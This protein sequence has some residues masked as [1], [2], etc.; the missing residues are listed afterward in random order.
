MNIDASPAH[1]VAAA[2]HANPYP[3]Y[4]TL[5]D[6]HA[7]VYDTKLHLWLASTASAV[8]AAFHH[9]HLSVRP[10]HDPVP[11]AI[12]QSS[13][14]E[15]FGHLV[16][17]NDGARHNQ[18]K[19]ALELALATLELNDVAHRAAQQARLHRP[20]TD[21][22]QALAYAL[23]AGMFQVP[24][25]TVAGL[26]GFAPEQWPEVVQWMGD[27]VAC[28]SPL[29]SA[30]QLTAAST[31]AQAL[32]DRLGALVAQSQ[33]QAGQLLR[34]VLAHAG[35]C[36][37]QDQRAVLCNLVGLMSQTYEATAGLIGNTWVAL[38]QRPVLLDALIAE[39]KNASKLAARVHTLV[40]S[41]C[42]FDAPIQNTRR[43]VT[44]DTE[45]E[46]TPLP[47]GSVV[48]LLLGSANRDTQGRPLASELQLQSAPPPYF[49][50]GRG[51]HAC[52]GRALAL[53]LAASAITQLLL[54]HQGPPMQNLA[55]LQVSYRPSVNAR[56]PLFS[57]AQ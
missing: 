54:S 53:T 22:A 46:G 35:T 16:R 37:W 40:D 21:S 50:F 29:S 47:A 20:A 12:A 27:F 38:I 28:L 2:T 56:I 57:A 25:T 9:Q 6:T 31:S 1:A 42:C 36:G 26:L 55:G 33:P 32:L 5:R 17:M 19:L 51:V 8:L 30:D 39:G 44:R 11:L 7:L 4:S 18:P 45:L 49:S 43:F 41:V 3:W 52:P 14:G 24:V 23:N 13:A 10:A 34:S 48:L 15:V